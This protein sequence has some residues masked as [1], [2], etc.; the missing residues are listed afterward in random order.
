MCNYTGQPSLRPVPRHRGLDEPLEA[1]QLLG[2]EEEVDA[3]DQ[4]LLFADEAVAFE[5][6]NHL[7][8]FRGADPKMALYVGLDRSLTEPAPVDTDEG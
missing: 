4:A 5:G 7:H 6:A 3:S 8:G 1:W 2:R